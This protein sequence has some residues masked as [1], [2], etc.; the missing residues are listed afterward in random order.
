MRIQWRHLISGSRMEDRNQVRA[1]A[2][3]P[4]KSLG[5]MRPCGEMQG[6]TKPRE[7]PDDLFRK[8]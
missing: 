6:F 7:I 4:V 1:D 8:D 2:Y 3:R 5:K